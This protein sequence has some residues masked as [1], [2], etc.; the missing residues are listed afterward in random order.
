MRLVSGRCERYLALGSRHRK[1][2]QNRAVGT[3]RH[4]NDGWYLR[5]FN[6]ASNRNAV[7]SLDELSLDED[8]LTM[9]KNKLYLTW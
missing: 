6:L 3:F 1:I 7:N 2:I 8:N 4:S 5:S 9:A